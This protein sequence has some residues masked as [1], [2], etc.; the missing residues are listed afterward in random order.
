MVADACRYIMAAN[1]GAPRMVTLWNARMADLGSLDFGFS[2]PP[3]GKGEAASAHRG[4][5]LSLYVE[6]VI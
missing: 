6:R 5:L 3:L 1:V 4:G 2:L